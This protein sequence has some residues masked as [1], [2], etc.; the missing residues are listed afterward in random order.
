MHFLHEPPHTEAQRRA[1]H[2]RR[3]VRW[4]W[5]AIV[6]VLVAFLVVDREPVAATYA[7][8]GFV[9]RTVEAA[10]RVATPAIYA[11][12]AMSSPATTAQDEA[13][14]EA[15][16]GDMRPDFRVTFAGLEDAQ[17]GTPLTYTVQVRN[18]GQSGG[19][20]LVTTILPPELSNVRV[21][22]PG[23][24]CS[25]RF[26]AGGSQPGTLVS[27]TRSNLGP[28]AL[29][30]MTIEANAPRTPSVYALSARADPRDD[31]AEANESNNEASATIRVHG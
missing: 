9:E 19:V 27:C 13:A 17:P 1:Q 3:S 2:R 22:A 20:V 24:V 21:N 6:G 11:D 30:E 7:A 23:F 29:A 14:L 16:K 4:H 8:S 18:Q 15:L 28:G 12:S 26:A 5:Q 25:R 10:R 31:V